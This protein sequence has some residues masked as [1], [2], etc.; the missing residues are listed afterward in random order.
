MLVS[1]ALVAAPGCRPVRGNRLNVLLVTLET[2]RADHL[3]AYGYPRDTS[4][5]FDRAASQGVLFEHHSTVSPRTNPSLAA[6]LTSTYPHENGVRN[7]LLSLEPENRT[8]AEVLRAA[9]YAT[10]AVQTH[11]RLVKASGLAQGFRDYYDDVAAHPLANQA[12]AR[13]A[14]WM[15]DAS[16]G[17]RPWFLWIHLMDPHWTYDPPEPWRTRYV[18]EDPRTRA[19]YED[20]KAR[21]LTIGPIIFGNTMPPD[22][23]ASFIGLYDAELRFTD[24]ALGG[25]LQSVGDLGLAGKTL[26]VV[27]ADHGESLGE[28]DYFFEHGDLGSEPEVHIPL[29]FRWPGR[30]SEGRRIAS[31]VRSVDV[32]PT[33]L[34]LAGLPAEPAFR[35]QTLRPYLDGKEVADRA[36]FGETDM[37]FHEENLFREIPGILGKSRW[38]RRG[39]F[40]LV[41]VPHAARPADWRLYDLVADPGELENAGN[42]LPEVRD[43]LRRELGA[44]MAEDAGKE[45]DYH[46]GKEARE[47]LR[48][49]GYVN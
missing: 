3:G 8:L 33:I 36:C 47:Q 7:L 49:L 16:R 46:I 44:F 28:H 22:E 48:S 30:L 43:A 2:T 23:V 11:P 42:R 34:D 32:A 39:R 17:S 35:G 14:A 19:L 4:P 40:K 21:R 38:L 25:L 45:R 29:L 6:L 12:C 18:A 41:F 20:L 9:G 10:G 27:T 31:T 15:R 13:A 5:S 37:N 24:D 26:V 1:A